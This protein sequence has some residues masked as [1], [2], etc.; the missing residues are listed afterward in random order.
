MDNLVMFICD[1]LVARF[2]YPEALLSFLRPVLPNLC[3][4]LL[5]PNGIRWQV[6]YMAEKRHF[7]PGICPE[8]GGVVVSYLPKIVLLYHLV[9]FSGCIPN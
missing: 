5:L 6:K 1:Y 9:V 2:P 3:L 4:L 8:S 7:I